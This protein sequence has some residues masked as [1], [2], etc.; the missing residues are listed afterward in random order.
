MSTTYK[1]LPGDTLDNISRKIYG[2]ETESN[3]IMKANPDITGGSLQ[4]D[5]IIILPELPDAPKNILNNALPVKND[6]DVSIHIETRRFRFWNKIRIIRAIDTIDIVE[7]MSPF[8]ADAPKFKETF[9]PFSFKPL[10]ISVG[11]ERLFSGTMVGVQPFVENG[12]KILSIGGYSLPGVLN[13]CTSPASA[14]PLE[15][16]DLGLKDISIAMASPFGISVKFT[17]EAGSAFSRVANEPGERILSFL[18]TLAQQRNLV[19]GSTPNGE[20]LFSRSI[21]SGRPVAFL[22]QGVAPVINITPFFSPQEYYSHITGIEPVIVGLKG[23]QYTIKNSRLQGVT[24]PMTFSAPDALQND[25]E[26]AVAAKAGRM[27]ANMVSYSV[28]LSTWRDPGGNLWKPNTIVKLQAPEAMIY[29]EYD[30]IIRKVDF[31]CDEQKMTSR[32]DLVIPGSFSGKVPKELP[33]DK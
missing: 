16:N 2:T 9:R 23:S 22:S 15:F 19:I 30:F 31:K 25:L 4:I 32:L 5:S 7:F 17:S 10:N 21:E 11:G 3:L 27:F 26:G 33:W 13:D 24:R 6:N 29:E 28:Q 1:V 14:Y 20:L 8:D 12:R 18:T